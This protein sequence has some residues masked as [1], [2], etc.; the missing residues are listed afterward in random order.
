MEEDRYIDLLLK[1]ADA[2]INEQERLELA[3]WLDASEA[4]RDRANQIRK[5]WAL[6]VKAPHEISLDL[7]EQYQMVREKI[8][9]TPS[10]VPK[11]VQ[12]RSWQIAAGILLL[13]GASWISYR[14]L[15]SPSIEMLTYQGP[16]ENLKLP[17]GSTIWLDENAEFQYTTSTTSRQGI[18]TG[19]AYFEI[20]PD[21]DQPFEIVTTLGKVT[22]L[23]TS[24][25]IDA[26]TTNQLVVTVSEGKVRLSNNQQ[27]MIE[28]TRGETGKI[29]G[30]E[31]EKNNSSQPAGSW[32]LPPRIFDQESLSTVLQEIEEKY[33][34]RFDTEQASINQCKVSFTLSYPNIDELISIL[35]TLLS[36]QITKQGPAQFYITGSGC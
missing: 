8:L 10:A 9:K 32:R 19:K 26:S 36:V 22:V 29:S 14:I 31:I 7:E 5:A 23:G 11:T 33:L 3:N 16:S 30:S 1:E 25:E 18:L 4:N 2:Q 6:S 17:D 28:L 27:A 21:S 35:E 24:F 12:L 13:I 15:Q 20:K 34:V